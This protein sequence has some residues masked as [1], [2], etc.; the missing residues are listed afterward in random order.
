M[1][2]WVC[3]IAVDIC[4]ICLAINYK[5]R[6]T[7]AEITVVQKLIKAVPGIRLYIDPGGPFL[8]TFLGK[9]KSDREN[10]LIDR[11]ALKN[12]TRLDETG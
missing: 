6:I 7:Y 1:K 3:I 5:S 11:I 10:K 8:V 2:G 12:K 4:R 9:Q